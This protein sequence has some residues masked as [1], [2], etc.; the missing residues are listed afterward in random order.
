MI[1]SVLE[2]ILEFVLGGRVQTTVILILLIGVVY[3]RKALGIG[4]LLGDWV[5]KI[6]FTLVVLIVLL[7]SGIIPGINVSAVL[8]IVDRGLDL[9]WS[10][11]DFITS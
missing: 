10:V 8:W 4:S 5:G 11:V 2:P 1:S 9:G 6:T 7:V 3:F